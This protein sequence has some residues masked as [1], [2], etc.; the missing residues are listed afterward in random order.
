MLR[1]S[2]GQ[3]EIEAMIDVDGET[4]TAP[5]WSGLRCVLGAGSKRETHIGGSIVA[6]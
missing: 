4:L 5:W 3:R 6:R 1:M 2:E